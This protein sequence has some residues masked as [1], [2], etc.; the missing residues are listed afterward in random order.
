MNL[1]KDD[2]DF[3]VS[4]LLPTRNGKNSLYYPTFCKTDKGLR[5][6]GMHM[7]VEK[8][9]QVR[10]N[11]A[12]VANAKYGLAQLCAGRPCRTIRLTMKLMD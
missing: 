11:G 7:V 3:S 6:H 4:T 8:N 9:G 5:L 12:T 10:A 1:R 2:Q